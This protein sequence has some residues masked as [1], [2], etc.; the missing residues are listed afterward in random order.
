MERVTFEIAP[1]EE[2]IRGAAVLAAALVLTL[3]AMT[4]APW[5]IAQHDGE[6][7]S[8]RLLSVADEPYLTSMPSSGLHMLGVYVLAVFE[9]A[10]V[11]RLAYMIVTIVYGSPLVKRGLF[12]SKFRVAW[13]S[14]FRAQVFAGIVT[15]SAIYSALDIPTLQVSGT[16]VTLDATVRYSWGGALLVIACIV[17]HVGLY[18]IA[19]HPLLAQSQTWELPASMQPQPVP[20]PVRA[21]RPMIKSPLP[22][23]PNLDADPFRSPPRASSIEDKLVRPALPTSTPAVVKSDNVDEPSLLR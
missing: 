12:R 4:L 17:A 22:P 8:V 18:L 16:D 1:L 5:Y 15:I 6:A 10:F 14:A 2:R 7:L 19:R 11:V 3:I 23:P 21:S 20:A 13:K 9:V